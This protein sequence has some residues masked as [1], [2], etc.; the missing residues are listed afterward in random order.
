LLFFFQ[1]KQT[2]QRCGHPQKLQKN[3]IKLAR[4]SK[5]HAIAI[6]SR[7]KQGLVTPEK[8]THP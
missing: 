4:S 1:K 6:H 5:S 8:D 3:N 2:T 7:T